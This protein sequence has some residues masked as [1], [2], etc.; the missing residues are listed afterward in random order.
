MSDLIEQIKQRPIPFAAG[1]L[2][3]TQALISAPGTV[4]VMERNQ[5][6]RNANQLEREQQ[7]RLKMEAQLQVERAAI[8][9]QRYAKGCLFIVGLDN[10]QPMNISDGMT[11]V[12]RGDKTTPIADGAY[13]CD[14]WGMTGVV[15]NGVVTDT[16][17]TGKPQ[18]NLEQQP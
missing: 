5:A 14:R 12:N 16:A 6:L 1:A 2:L 4:A 8:A 3:L 18:L 7:Q 11:I 17:F 15:R 9:E 13:V 10:E